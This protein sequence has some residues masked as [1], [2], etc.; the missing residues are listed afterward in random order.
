MPIF[1]SKSKKAEAGSSSAATVDTYDDDRD[2]GFSTLQL[3]HGQ[4]YDSDHRARAP[5]IYASTSFGFKDAEHGAKLFALQELGPIYTRIMNPTSHMFEY[6]I[7]KLEGSGC[8]LDG[9]HPSALA[10]AS[11]QA[12]QMHTMF[13]LCSA[14]D[15]FIASN[16]LYGGT[17]AQFA[18]TF[19]NMGVT[20]KFF[21]CTKPEEIEALIDENTKAVYME[22]IANPSYSVCD[23]EAVSAI[24]KKNELPLVVDN[25][26]GMCGFTCRPI[27]FGAN[28]VTASCTKWIGGHGNTIGGII[29]DANNFDWSVKKADGTSKFPL[30]NDP[31][32]LTTA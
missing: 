27:K 23:F 5:P 21:D 32:P 14:G 25:T 26:F 18:H 24:C 1:K 16:N 4:G 3:H 2:V 20:V 17:Y 29:I 11:G 31:S 8:D 30:L 28:I 22:T 10:T 15:N 19:K 9:A 12:A 7:A 6:R 13:T